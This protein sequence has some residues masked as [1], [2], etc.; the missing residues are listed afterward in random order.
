M[1]FL[2][3]TLFYFSSRPHKSGHLV[4]FQEKFKGWAEPGIEPPEPRAAQ[5]GMAANDFVWQI[6]EHFR[7]IVVCTC[8]LEV[9]ELQFSSAKLYTSYK[10]SYIYIEK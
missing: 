9:S 6:A 2:T 3:E 1:T 7:Q 5:P 4:Y 8:F 10:C